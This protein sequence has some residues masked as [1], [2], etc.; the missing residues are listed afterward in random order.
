[1]E[2]H[3]RPLV[4]TG[5]RDGLRRCQR[6]H[7]LQGSVIDKT[8]FDTLKGYVG[9]AKSD[10]D[11]DVICGGECDD[12]RGYFVAPT[13]IQAHDPHYV[14]METELFGPVLTVYVYRDADYEHA[15]ELCDRTSPYALT[16]RFSA[17]TVARLTSRA[18][19]SA[20]PLATSTSTTSPPAQ[21]S[22]SNRSAG[23][24]HPAQTTKLAAI[25]I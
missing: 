9:A 8:S 2:A 5:Q 20:T 25:S 19:S 3:P 7:E 13:I 6:L 21:L 4:R 16:A 10:A 11:A 17:P 22:A 1:M 24:A 15:L 12:S 18:R 14:T 23:H